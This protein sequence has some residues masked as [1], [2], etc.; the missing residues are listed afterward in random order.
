MVQ[1]RFLGLIVTRTDE[2]YIHP[3]RGIFT[4]SKVRIEYA[5]VILD[6]D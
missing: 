2:K 4:F 1:K 3:N 6:P 5:S